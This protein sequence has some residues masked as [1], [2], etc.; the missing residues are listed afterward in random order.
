MLIQHS[1]DGSNRKLNAGDG[2]RLMSASVLRL[3]RQRKRVT[4]GMPQILLN[5]IILR[6]L[7][8]PTRH[9]NAG[10]AASIK[11]KVLKQDVMERLRLRSSR[12]LK[13]IGPPYAII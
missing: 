13:H 8:V 3:V 11:K 5:R 12:T 1:K 7:P 4:N 6:S 10:S 9:Q 2:K